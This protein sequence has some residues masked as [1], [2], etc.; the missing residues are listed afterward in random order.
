MSQSNIVLIVTVVAVQTVYMYFYAL[1]M[2][3]NY[4]AFY[5]YFFQITI[6]PLLRVHC[7]LY[8]FCLF[9]CAASKVFCIFI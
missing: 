3:A 1:K 2:S 9:C 6:V 8:I 5:F 4:G 7:L